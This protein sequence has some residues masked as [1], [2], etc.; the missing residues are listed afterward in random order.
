MGLRHRNGVWCV[1]GLIAVMSTMICMAGCKTTQSF[2]TGIPPVQGELVGGGL[3]IEWT[4]PVEG[5]A[6]LVEETT[7]RII[8]TRSLDQGDTYSFS[9]AAE[10][11]K[12]EFER[13]FGMKPA[14]ARF[15]LYF[16]AAKP[17]S[18]VQ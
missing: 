10:G 18:V 13:I 6:Y 11:Q 5:T 17:K 14:E 7:N 12:S 8:E 2:R 1:I 3:K 9:P 15:L 16:Q 4:A